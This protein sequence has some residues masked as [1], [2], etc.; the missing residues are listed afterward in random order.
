MKKV[1]HRKKAVYEK[2]IVAFVDILGF[3]TIIDDSVCDTSLRRKVLEA[4]EIIHSRREVNAQ[5][6]VL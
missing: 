6:S 4:T 1:S 5:P 2:R 3:K